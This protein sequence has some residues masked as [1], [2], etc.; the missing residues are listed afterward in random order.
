MSLETELT[1]RLTAAEPEIIAI[2]RYLHAHP[3]VSFHEKPPLLTSKT[4]T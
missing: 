3:E 1:N 2:R 4:F